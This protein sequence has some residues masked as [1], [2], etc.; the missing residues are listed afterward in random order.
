MPDEILQQQAEPAAPATEQPAV[1]QDDPARGDAGGEASDPAPSPEIES[2]AR[3]MG[4]VPKDQFRGNP[5]SW[6][7]ADEFVR[8]G[9]EFLPIV[10][11]SLEKERRRTAE[12][13][14]Q[15][16]TQ[17]KEFDDRLRR[18]DKVSQAALQ[19]QAAQLHARY[20]AAKREAASVGDVE[21]YDRLNREHAEEFQRF[22]SSVPAEPEPEKAP[23]KVPAMPPEVQ[24]AVAVW[25]DRHADW[26]DKD[27]E[28]TDMA[29]N[30]HSTLLR[31]RPRMTI[32]QNLAEVEERMA[33]MY[34]G[35]I[36]KAAARSPAASL[37]GG[38]RQPG[39]MS[40]RGKGWADIPAD[41][42]K[43]G[44]QFITRDGLFLPEGVSLAKATDRDIA[45]ARA[46]YAKEYWS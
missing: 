40:P 5:D 19:N 37:E 30:I 28:L 11:S 20:N 36:K 18:L 14:A 6:R 4:W 31:N 27:A 24:Q 10:R 38:S 12:L 2:R 26:W 8:R 29:V 23:A 17:R 1:T 35:R 21:R 16:A 43:Q 33:A 45:A 34:P 15:I 32:E 7:P 25:T 9:E 39:S 22:E 3:D 44:E 46:A 13:E 41:D 42:R